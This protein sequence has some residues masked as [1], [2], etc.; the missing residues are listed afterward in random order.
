MLFR[1][2]I[3][4]NDR[5]RLITALLAPVETD[6]EDREL[7]A[8][9]L[10]ERSP[11]DIAA[12]LVRA[13]RAKMPA[14]EELI[15]GTHEAQ[16]AAQVERHRPGFDDVVWF[17]MDVGRRQ[18]ADARWILPLLC[19]RGHITRNEVGAIRIGQHETHFQVPSA[20][21]RKFADAVKRT[22]GVEGDDE[23]GI[24][25]EHSESPPAQG[26]P[27]KPRGGPPPKPHRGQGG[28]AGKSANRPRV[29]HKGKPKGPRG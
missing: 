9:L 13:H 23:S 10:A 25:I 7:A 5:E 14:P 4:L 12:A 20:V 1:S 19:R 8:R 29:F 24:T 15:P 16:R 22:A 26:A 18:N 21:A 6:E 17:R 3:R 2:D 28:P 11:E 27:H